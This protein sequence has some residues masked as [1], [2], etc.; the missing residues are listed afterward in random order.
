MLVVVNLDALRKRSL[1]SKIILYVGTPTLDEILGQLLALLGSGLAQTQIL[2]LWVKHPD[3][4]LELFLLSR[5]G[6]GSQ[7]NDVPVCCGQ[8]V[9]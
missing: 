8:M 4:G 6:S 3:D 1:A 7:H 5:M 2:K 9:K